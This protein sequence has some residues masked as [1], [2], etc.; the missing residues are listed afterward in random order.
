MPS[1]C[2]RYNVLLVLCEFLMISDLVIVIIPL[3][4]QGL[5]SMGA[6]NSNMELRCS[7]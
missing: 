3:I 6:Q 5:I 4:F 2:L 1:M 7:W